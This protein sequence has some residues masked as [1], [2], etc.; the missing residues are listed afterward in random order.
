MEKF[1][2][3]LSQLI[4]DKNNF[5]QKTKSILEKMQKLKKKEFEKAKEAVKPK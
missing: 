4:K 3:V 5:E 2:I 1:K